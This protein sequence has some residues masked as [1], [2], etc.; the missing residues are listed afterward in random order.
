MLCHSSMFILFSCIVVI[1]LCFL[2]YAAEIQIICK[3][4]KNWEKKE[5]GVACYGLYYGLSGVS[6]YIMLTMKMLAARMM[7]FIN[8]P[9]RMKS[10]KR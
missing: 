1:I 10:L 7:K 3:L 4:Q 9:M 6:G 5:W 2:F 8:R